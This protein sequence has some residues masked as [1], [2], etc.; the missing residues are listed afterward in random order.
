MEKVSRVAAVYD[1]HGNLPA[2]EAVLADL[3]GVDHDLLVVGGDVAS[4]P[5]PTAVLDRLED[6]GDSVRWVRGNADREIVAAYDRGTSTSDVHTSDPVLRA[7][8]WSASRIGRR[9]RDLMTSF[10]ETL[11]STCA[12]GRSGTSCRA[13]RAVCCLSSSREPSWK[14]GGTPTPS[15]GFQRVKN[16]HRTPAHRAGLP[17]RSLAG[18]AHCYMVEKFVVHTSMVK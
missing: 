16:V 12:R 7:S 6:I 4:G 13:G 15:S 17:C 3:E 11:G 10:Q 9:Q 14:Q 2:L 5:M 18:F 8:A 1:V